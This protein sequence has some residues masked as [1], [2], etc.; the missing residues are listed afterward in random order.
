MIL[1]R[2][3]ASTA[4][5]AATAPALHAEEN[6]PKDQ[7]TTIVVTATPFPTCRMK[8]LHPRQGRCRGDPQRGSAS[9]ADALK[10]VP[11]VAASGF[12]QGIAPGDPRHGFQ[13][14]APA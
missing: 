2:L 9:I 14:R 3:L 13:P 4:L 10:N 8:R 11:G 6:A 12:A 7:T 5:I 1:T